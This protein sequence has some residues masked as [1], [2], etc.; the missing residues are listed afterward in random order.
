VIWLV[1]NYG[2]QR[3]E[4]IWSSLDGAKRERSRLIHDDRSRPI[5]V[6]KYR[7]DEREGFMGTSLTNL[8]SPDIDYRWPGEED[9]AA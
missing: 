6:L 4:S 5:G 9:D 7:L 8:A 1:W 2:S 3:P